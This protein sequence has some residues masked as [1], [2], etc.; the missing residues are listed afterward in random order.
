MLL[1]LG[2]AYGIHAG[3]T[4]LAEPMF[5][6]LIE[7]DPLSPLNY[8]VQCIFQIAAGQL[9]NAIDS[10]QK[11]SDLSNNELYVNLFSSVVYAMQKKYNK[12][13]QM[14]ENVS[15]LKFHS[16]IHDIFIDW[17]TF[18]KHALQ[19]D[20]KDARNTIT[21]EVT[22][23]F[24][25]D[26]EYMWLGVWSYALVDEKE[27]ALKWLEHIIDRGF[28]NYPFLSERA[29]FIEKLRNEPLYKKLMKRVKHEWEYFGVDNAPP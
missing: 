28:I 1:F 29:P 19:G 16:K 12:A 17:C 18:L 14:A 7:S 21:E 20:I 11:F 4:S 22:T 27:E 2:N 26:P 24:W 15:A 13:I 3:K 25:N 9:E 5:N 10:C 6:R 23:Y 8:G